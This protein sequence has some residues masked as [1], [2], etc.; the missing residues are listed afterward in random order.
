MDHDFLFQWTPK[1]EKFLETYSSGGTRVSPSTPE[2]GASSLRD[3]LSERGPT[4]GTMATA[5]SKI[6]ESGP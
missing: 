2:P 6:M 4:S 1:R 3:A 5:A